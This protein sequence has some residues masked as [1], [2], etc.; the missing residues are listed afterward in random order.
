MARKKKGHLHQVLR[1]R[2]R[3]AGYEGKDMARKLACC[4]GS[5]SQKLNGVVPWQSWEMHAVMEALGARPEEM[6]ELFPPNGEDVP[7]IR[8]QRIADYLADR[9]ETAVSTPVLETM[10]DIVHR[11]VPDRA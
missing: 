3:A 11:L 7:P 6:Y 10:L 1:Q 5:F 9:N 4:P 8:E 2:M